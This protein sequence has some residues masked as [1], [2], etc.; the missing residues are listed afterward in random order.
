MKPLFEERVPSDEGRKRTKQPF[1]DYRGT[2][3]TC[4]EKQENSL[5]F[6]FLMGDEIVSR[7]LVSDL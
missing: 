3:L 5:P 4:D 1:P 2:L 7:G 6:S